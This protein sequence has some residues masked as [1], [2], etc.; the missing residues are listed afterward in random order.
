MKIDIFLAPAERNWMQ[1]ILLL[2]ANVR[3]RCAAY[4]HSAQCTR[5]IVRVRC[6]QHTGTRVFRKLLLNGAYY[7]S[8]ID[9]IWFLW[10]GAD[11]KYNICAMLIPFKW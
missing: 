3:V 10:A 9:C 11:K 1:P 2:F 7:D 5:T 8:K 4:L 6:M